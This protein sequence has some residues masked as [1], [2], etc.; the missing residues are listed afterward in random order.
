MVRTSKGTG[1]EIQEAKLTGVVPCSLLK[2]DRSFFPFL[3]IGKLS[4]HPFVASLAAKVRV[5]L[6]TC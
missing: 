5:P 1:T 3:E 6:Q 2:A 4:N